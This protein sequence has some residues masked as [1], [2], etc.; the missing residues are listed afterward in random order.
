MMM[1]DGWRSDQDVRGGDKAR[2]QRH[3]YNYEHFSDISHSTRPGKPTN[4]RVRLVFNRSIN[5]AWPSIPQ[6]VGV[7]SNSETQIG[8]PRVA[9]APYR[10]SV[11]QC[12]LVSG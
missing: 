11:V 5:S 12:K 6:W 1:Q 9:L 2:P 10:W 3:R 7:P 8:A 4:C